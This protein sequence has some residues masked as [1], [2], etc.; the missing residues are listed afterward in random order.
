MINMS[1]LQQDE[2][3]NFHIDEFACPG[4]AHLLKLVKINIESTFYFLILLILEHFIYLGSL[5]FSWTDD[6][7]FFKVEQS[8]SIKTEL[9]IKLHSKQC[10][11]NFC[12]VQNLSCQIIKQLFK[13]IYFK[14]IVFALFS[15]LVL[16]VFWFQKRSFFKMINLILKEVKSAWFSFPYLMKFP[17]SLAAFG[18]KNFHIVHCSSIISKC[19]I[20]FSL[21]T[22]L[23]FC[24]YFFYI[25]SYIVFCIFFSAFGMFSL[26][27]LV[28]LTIPMQP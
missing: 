10:H 9:Q 24:L 22:F 18:T 5:E 26:M 28:I 27:Q 12:N 15:Q 13:K 11:T 17:R 6:V 25:F 3:K 14:K 4:T 20:L 19:H 16:I 21:L 8:K 7:A 2:S 23:I 1:S